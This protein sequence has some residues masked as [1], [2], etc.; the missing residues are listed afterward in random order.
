M[1]IN[2][3][4][5]IWVDTISRNDWNGSGTV[6]DGD[7]YDEELG[8]GTDKRGYKGD[9]LQIFEKETVVNKGDIGMIHI[10][11]VGLKWIVNSEKE[12]NKV[13][14]LMTDNL[15]M[16]HL[17]S[18]S[19]MLDPSASAQK[20]FERYPNQNLSIWSQRCIANISINDDLYSIDVFSDQNIGIPDIVNE[21]F[22]FAGYDDI[23]GTLTL[24][25]ALV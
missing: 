14:F 15:N 13:P 1:D 11:R 10:S 4:M 16:K 2:K 23:I 8:F 17:F 7:S 12:I 18:G 9:F 21:D 3:G 24:Y 22:C 5:Y 25:P 6:V 20:A 19:I